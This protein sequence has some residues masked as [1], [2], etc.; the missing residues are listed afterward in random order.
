MRLA[1]RA[2]NVILMVCS[3]SSLLEISEQSRKIQTA[4]ARAISQCDLGLRTTEKLKNFF[5]ENKIKE[6]MF[7][8]QM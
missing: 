4:G 6:K 8:K 3:K 1:F 7:T 5:I 2:Q